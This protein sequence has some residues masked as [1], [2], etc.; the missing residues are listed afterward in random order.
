MD[1]VAGSLSS[2]PTSRIPL[3]LIGTALF[4]ATVIGPNCFA[5]NTKVHKTLTAFLLEEAGIAHDS[6]LRIAEIDEGMDGPETNAFRSLEMRQRYHF[7]S[8]R[9]LSNLRI[10]AFSTCAAVP[11]GRFLH[12]LEDSFSHEG[13]GAV[14]GHG[15]TPTPDWPDNDVP[16]ALDMARTKFFEAGLIRSQCS[17]LR[18]TRTPQTWSV[19]SNRVRDFLQEP[20]V[21]SIQLQ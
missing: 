6:A 12:A 10:E 1:G 2:H 7:V 13:Y 15:W 17:A 16:K 18:G 14:L 5:Y 11:L 9:Q 19:I 3:V 4:A 8:A 20:K 21:V